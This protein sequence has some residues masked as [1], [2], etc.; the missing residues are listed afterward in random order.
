[1]ISKANNDKSCSNNNI[2]NH[3]EKGKKKFVDKI[4]KITKEK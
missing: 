3:D 4:D 2:E 1:V